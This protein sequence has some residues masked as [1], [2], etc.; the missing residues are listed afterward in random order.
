MFLATVA[1]FAVKKVEEGEG[2]EAFKTLSLLINIR[3]QWTIRDITTHVKIEHYTSVLHLSA[4]TEVCNVGP[5]SQIS[6]HVPYKDKMFL[7][8][9]CCCRNA[10][11]CILSL[12]K[13]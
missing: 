10:S 9:T 13:S 12:V 6:R 4:L 2:K 3:S 7:F 1:Q 5:I 8:C 11:S